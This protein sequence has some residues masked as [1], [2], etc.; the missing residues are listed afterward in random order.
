MSQKFFKDK[1]IHIIIKYNLIIVDYSVVT[2]N[3]NDGTCPI[4]DK[5]YHGATFIH[6]KSNHSPK[7]I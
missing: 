1:C 2:L 5:F 7:N 6:V 3:L 4:F